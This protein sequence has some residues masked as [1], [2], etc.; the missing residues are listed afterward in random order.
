MIMTQKTS[1]RPPW[2]KKGDGEGGG[3]IIKIF[4]SIVLDYLWSK[5]I[6]RPKMIVWSGATFILMILLV[7]ILYF[8]HL[9]SNLSPRSTEM[10]DIV[11]YNP[12]I[13]LIYFDK[14]FH[15][16]SSPR[17]M[18]GEYLSGC[19]VATDLVHI[20]HYISVSSRC[21]MINA[22]LSV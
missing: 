16:S 11:M 2:S 5:K 18:W 14:Y 17:W 8:C 20:L 12:Q 1:R 6:Y 22:D 3:S 7:C 4:W 21:W 19:E 10:N 9:H 13:L 15:H